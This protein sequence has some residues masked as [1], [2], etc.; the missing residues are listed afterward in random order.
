MQSI[1]AFPGHRDLV[2]LEDGGSHVHLD[3]A[4]LQDF[5]HF[6][7]G[8]RVDIYPPLVGQTLLAR[9]ECEAADAIAAH[10][11]YRTVRVHVIHEDVCLPACRRDPDDSV[12]SDAESAITESSHDFGGE[13]DPV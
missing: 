10:L 3:E 12:G 1:T 4:V 13:L 9:E 8:S 11:S 6:R 7:A 5:D 2:G